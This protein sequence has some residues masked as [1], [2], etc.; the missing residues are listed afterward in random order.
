MNRLSW[1]C[2]KRCEDVLRHALVYRTFATAVLSLAD[3]AHHPYRL[4]AAHRPVYRCSCPYCE[5]VQEMSRFERICY[6]ACAVLLSA[7]LIGFGAWL[8]LAP[9]PAILYP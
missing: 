5:E 1:N 9:M 8:M 3:L 4:D 6:I 2:I 7:W